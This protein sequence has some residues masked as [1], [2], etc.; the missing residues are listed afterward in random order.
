MNDAIMQI[1][2]GE[3]FGAKIVFLNGLED[4]CEE[5]AT[6]VV[7]GGVGGVGFGSVVVEGVINHLLLSTLKT[8]LYNLDRPFTI[9]PSLSLF[10]PPPQLI[11][12]PFNF[13]SHA[14]LPS[15][16]PPDLPSLPQSRHL[17]ENGLYSLQNGQLVRHHFPI[18]RLARSHEAG[19]RGILAASG[20]V[21]Y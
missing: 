19:I 13:K 14:P 1:I 9:Q 20:V 8:P 2:L 7:G 17:Q 6:E 3:I 10:P 4:V 15:Q 18:H 16:T 5:G 11:L 21:S 12:L